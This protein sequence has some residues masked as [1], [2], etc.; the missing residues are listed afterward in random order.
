MPV[1][2]VRDMTICELCE[3]VRQRSFVEP[4]THIVAESSSARYLGQYQIH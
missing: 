1:K 4:R 2:D 3:S